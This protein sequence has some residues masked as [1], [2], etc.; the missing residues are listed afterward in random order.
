MKIDLHLHSN[1]SDGDFS[2][3]KLVREFKRAGH[4]AIALFDH[5]TVKGVPE[6]LRAGKKYNIMTVPGVEMSSVHKGYNLHIAGLGIDHTNRN[7]RQRFRRYRE[8][9]VKRARQIVKKLQKLGFKIS[10]KE[11]RAKAGGVVNRPHI[12]QALLEKSA[13]QELLKK[14]TRKKLT[15]SH[16]IQAL[17][18]QG[19][20][21][22][23]RYQKE[24]TASDIKRIQAAG[25]LA[26]FCHPWFSKELQ[27]RISIEKLL[28]SLK[29]IGID[30]IEAFPRPPYSKQKD[31][32]IR[33]ARK[34][35]LIP[36]SGSDFHGP[37]HNQKIPKYQTPDWVL[38][39]I[40]KKLEK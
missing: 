8:A 35:N 6:F 3:T 25:G 19:K 23:V 28:R 12:A 18:S 14:F 37:V 33:L 40:L 27:P 10:F 4:E 24:S 13:N 36:S 15:A 5:D 11:V 26:I 21:A 39:D 31:K 2:P 16:V 38:A 20:P 1:A 32:Y 30:G 29:R 22:Y 9:R 34:Y 17:I 7:L